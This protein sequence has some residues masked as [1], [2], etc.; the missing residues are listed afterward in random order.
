[1]RQYEIQGRIPLGK[2]YEGPDFYGCINSGFAPAIFHSKKLKAYCD[3]PRFAVGPGLYVFDAINWRIL[4]N[5]NP[6]FYD[7]D[8]DSRRRVYFYSTYKAAKGKFYKLCQSVLDSNQQ[9]Q[10]DV[11]ELKKRAASGDVGAALNLSDY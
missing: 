6:R 10:A 7:V 3:G 11:A 9:D 1:M 2:G 8:G 4:T 5:K